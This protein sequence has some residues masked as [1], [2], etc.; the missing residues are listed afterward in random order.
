MGASL[1]V[2]GSCDGT[3]RHD[4]RQTEETVSHRS[5]GTSGS[6]TRH[7]DPRG[8]HDHRVRDE[9]SLG[10]E[11]Q[12][13]ASRETMKEKAREW[14]RQIRSETRKIDRDISRVRQEEN[15]LKKEITAMAKKGQEEGVRTLA[16]QVVRSRKSVAML[17][18]TKCSMTAMN[19]QLT[20]A[21][22]SFST[23]SSLKMSASMMQAMNQ[24]TNVPELQKT[25]AE[26][27]TELDRAEVAEEIM[28]EGLAESDDEAEADSEV[29]KVYEELA[30]D[31]SQLL[32]SGSAPTRIP[33][34]PSAMPTQQVSS[35]DPLA[36]R[37]QAL[38]QG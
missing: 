20:T 10:H 19:L 7:H 35:G 5:R 16:K 3:D 37:L 13:H 4:E 26:M 15:R 36:Q 32:A 18:R 27:R 23:A 24:L 29:E 11:L 30:L 31:T 8:Y 38:H 22:A 28:Q 14:Q 6:E 33:A 34:N 2:L 9:G 25:M 17:E 12:Q 1:D 21:I